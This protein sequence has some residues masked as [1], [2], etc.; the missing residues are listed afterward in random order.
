MLNSLCFTPEVCEVIPEYDRIVKSVCWYKIAADE[1]QHRNF[2]MWYGRG[3]RYCQER[4]GGLGQC[5]AEESREDS[6]VVN[7][8]VPHPSRW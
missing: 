3:D 7:V 6:S 8:S 1:K 5:G 2:M 4:E